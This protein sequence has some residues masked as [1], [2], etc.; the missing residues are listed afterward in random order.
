VTKADVALRRF[1]Q[2][3]RIAGLA[4]SYTFLTKPDLADLYAARQQ[5]G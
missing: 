1:S 3:D 2:K 5:V 4:K